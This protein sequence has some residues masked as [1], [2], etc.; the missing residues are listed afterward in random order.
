MT[1]NGTFMAGLQSRAV[2]VATSAPFDRFAS[3]AR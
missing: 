2:A 3:F 1:V